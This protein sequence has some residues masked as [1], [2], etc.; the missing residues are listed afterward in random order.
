MKG[1]D[2]A[3]PA[4]VASRY[5]RKLINLTNEMTRTTQ[6]E[7]EQLFRHPDVV[8][9][10]AAVSP[11]KHAMDISPASQARILT[12]KLAA[13]FDDL[14]AQAAKPYAEGMVDEADAASTASVGMSL[15]ELAGG[16]HMKIAVTTPV[17]EEFK[18]AIIANNVS[19]IKSIPSEFFRDVQQA[20][21]SSITDGKGNDDL[22]SFFRDRHGVEERRAK[23]IA[24][25]QT[26]KAYNG[27]N[28][29]RLQDAGVKKFEWIHSGGGLHPRPLHL[30]QL[31]GR[32]F[33]FD[34][35]PIIEEGT[36]E[37]GIPGQAINCRCTMRPVVEIGSS[38]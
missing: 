5:A 28:K 38:T 31:N 1:A 4:G 7:V 37:R 35:L 19:L 9:H 8:A 36:G 20:V 10:L 18:K 26:H 2:L 6:R 15:R 24:I 27:L 22:S 12:N 29:V 13:R 33:S 34:K 17:M 3:L 21:L 11:V 32:I 25:D 23:N 14:F 30:D 16:L